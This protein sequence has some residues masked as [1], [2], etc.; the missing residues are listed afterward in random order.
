MVYLTEYLLLPAL[1]CVA[2]VF[3]NILPSLTALN[4]RDCG[5]FM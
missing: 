3:A 4:N 2:T 1:L 5:I